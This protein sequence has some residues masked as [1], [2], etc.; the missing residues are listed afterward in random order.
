MKGLAFMEPILVAEAVAG[1]EVESAVMLSPIDSPPVIRVGC[2][3]HARR[4][5]LADDLAHLVACGYDAA[6]LP[7]EPL[8]CI[9]GARLV[10]RTT[11]LV[12]EICAEY[13][14]TLAYSMHSPAVL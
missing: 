12:A 9:L 14:G 4:A 5:G 8:G 1:V 10:E 7:I 2:D 11:A 13:D 6:E 3:V